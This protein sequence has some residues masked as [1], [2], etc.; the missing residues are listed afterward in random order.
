MKYPILLSLSFF[1]LLIMGSCNS[2]RVPVEQIDTMTKSSQDKVSNNRLERMANAWVGH[3]SNRKHIE[4]GDTEMTIEQE[5]IG[6]RIWKKARINE[7]WIY[8]GWYPANSYTTPLATSIAE[9]TKIAPDTAFIT[10]YRL[11]QHLKDKVDP[12]EW[13]K[14]QPFEEIERADLLSNGED[15]GC[16]IVRGEKGGYELI[17]KGACYDDISD[18]LKYYIIN[19]TM[20]SDRIAFNTRLL[21]AEQKEMVNYQNNVFYRMNKKELEK[22]YVELP[23]TSL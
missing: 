3:F 4:S 13:A 10:F 17:A 22:K 1:F 23:L 16:Y 6:R 18:Q 11:P 15:C 21:D 8:T 9:I 14:P 7:H 12:Y 5:L 20:K 2:N 19:A